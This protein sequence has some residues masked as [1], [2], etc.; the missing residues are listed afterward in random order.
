MNRVGLP[1][2]TVSLAIAGINPIPAMQLSIRIPIRSLGENFQIIE[3]DYCKR[4]VLPT[5]R[6]LEL[7]MDCAAFTTVLENL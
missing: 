4:R 1:G 3:T 6:E 5:P 2:K 7:A